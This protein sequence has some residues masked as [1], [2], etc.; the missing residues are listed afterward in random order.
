MG[1]YPS[2][3]TLTFLNLPLMKCILRSQQFY[4][5]E[6]LMYGHGVFIYEPGAALKKYGSWDGV[7]AAVVKMKMSHAWLRGH[8][9][10]GLFELKQNQKLI[11]ALR[12]VGVKVFIW[13]WSQGEDQIAKDI[14]NAADAISKYSPDGYVADIEQGV[15]GAKW[16]E[17]SITQFL[18][19]TRAT[20]EG[21][22]LVLSTHGFIPFHEPELMRAADLHIDAFAPQVYW[23]WY[24]NKRMFSQPGARGP[25]QTNN[26]ASYAD[27]CID[28]WRHVTEKPIII[29]GQA[30]WGEIQRW[31]QRDA[32]AKVQEFAD[33]FD[34]FHEIAGLNWWYL[35][36][37]AAMSPKMESIIAGADFGSRLAEAAVVAREGAESLYA[38]AAIA[39][40]E[41]VE[42][43]AKAPEVGAAYVRTDGL[44][45]RREPNTSASIAKCLDLGDEVDVM[46]ASPDGRWREVLRSGERGFA[47]AFYLR[48]PMSEEREALLRVAI[49]QWLRFA[50]GHANEKL[51]PYC[52][53]VGEMWQSLG[54]DYHGR[55]TYA[56][57]SDVPWSAAF[58]S[59]VVRTAHPRYSTFKFASAH[60]VFSNDA[61][62]ARR[63]NDQCKPF[64]G[65]RLTEVRPQ[66]GDI[67]VRNR[68]G[69]SFTFDY[70][71]NHS[72]FVS[73][74]DL[75]VEVSDG[76]IKVLGGNVKNSVSMSRYELNGSG[77]IDT[78]QDAFA[79]LRNRI[80]DVRDSIIA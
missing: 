5:G 42:A 76:A 46:S 57:G 55:S 14:K 20:L 28:V 67:I 23:F 21:K 37:D 34:R 61:I 44:N 74:S 24:P 35:A 18:R 2:K 54:E 72:N 69:N 66:L 27:L 1:T 15:S 80:E 26:A 68:L 9:R 33:S 47:V 56:D 75:V 41:V 7:A 62:L 40:T 65:Y 12:N 77:F 49:T 78:S 22:P 32:E 79:I 3:D 39:A 30:Y 8:G 11:S 59:F 51:D 64:W 13:G 43:A 48:P 16:S 71:E 31:R 17:D 63:S 50:K 4:R 6:E 36:G 10:N 19:T 25:Y 58:M 73:H 70:A 52:Q 53:Y 60:S 38:T 45:M 29:T